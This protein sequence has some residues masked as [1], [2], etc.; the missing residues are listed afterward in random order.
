MM[1]MSPAWERDANQ[2]VRENADIE[3]AADLQLAALDA[4]RLLETRSGAIQTPDWV[5]NKYLI[6]AYFR[7]SGEPAWYNPLYPNRRI[8][9]DRALKDFSSKRTKTWLWDASQEDMS[10]HNCFL[11]LLEGCEDDRLAEWAPL[12]I[13]YKTP[14]VVALTW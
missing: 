1:A 5:S 13:D 9:V 4:V 3:F 10:E 7:S 14:Y 8:L 2:A 11:D 12:A 6:Y